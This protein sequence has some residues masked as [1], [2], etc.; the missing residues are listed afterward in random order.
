MRTE[1]I[2][3]S[4]YQEQASEVDDKESARECQ[5]GEWEEELLRLKS[6]LVTTI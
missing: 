2:I 1:R 3:V 6:N 4:K 5:G